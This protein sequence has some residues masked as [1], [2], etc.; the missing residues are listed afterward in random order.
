MKFD[1]PLCNE[2]AISSDYTVYPD[3][4]NHTSTIILNFPINSYLAYLYIHISL[5]SWMNRQVIYL[6]WN[7]LRERDMIG[8]H[9][10]IKDLDLCLDL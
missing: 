6:L 3:I 4:T 1:F 2:S 10:N 8:D 5:Q 7:E 9:H